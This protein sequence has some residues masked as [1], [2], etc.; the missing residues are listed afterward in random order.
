[1]A[2]TWTVSQLDDY[3]VGPAGPY[4]GESRVVFTIHWQCTDQ[5]TV[6]DETYYARIYSSQ[7]LQPF[8]GGAAFTPWAEVT[9]AQALGWL[10]D[11]IGA[12][13]VSRIEAGVE[14]QLEAKINPT[15]ETGLPWDTGE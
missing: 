4:E 10:H 5:Q 7:G 11:K 1:M 15:T 12:D 9:E 14:A 2:A 3:I 6:D 13:E 8:T